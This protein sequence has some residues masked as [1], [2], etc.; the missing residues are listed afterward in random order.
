MLVPLLW[1]GCEL[2]HGLDYIGNKLDQ[3]PMVGVVFRATGVYR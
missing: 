1:V 3:G 2:G